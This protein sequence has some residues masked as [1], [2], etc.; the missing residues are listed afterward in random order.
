M[1]SG[2]ATEISTVGVTRLGEGYIYIYDKDVTHE[3]IKN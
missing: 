1:G 3:R 2:W